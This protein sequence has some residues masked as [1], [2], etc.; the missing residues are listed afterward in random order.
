MLEKIIKII[1]MRRELSKIH[2]IVKKHT[3]LSDLTLPEPCANRY[4]FKI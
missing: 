1:N 3:L 4:R 2:I